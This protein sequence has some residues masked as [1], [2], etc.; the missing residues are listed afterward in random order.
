MEVNRRDGHLSPGAGLEAWRPWA[1]QGRRCCP[2]SL[3]V[4]QR[5]G[6]TALTTAEQA[7]GATVNS[8]HENESLES[9]LS[10]DPD[11]G[12]EWKDPE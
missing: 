9:V 10:F 7:N 1:S 5:S 8:A 2:W 6:G 12:T 11:E 4:T 3:C